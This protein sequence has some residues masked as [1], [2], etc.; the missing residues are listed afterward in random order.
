MKRQAGQKTSSFFQQGR[1][2]AAFFFRKGLPMKKTSS[3]WIVALGLCVSSLGLLGNT[4]CGGGETATGGASPAPKSS[5]PSKTGAGAGGIGGT[6]APAPAKPLSGGSFVYIHTL[7]SG[8][9]TLRV[10]DIEEEGSRL[11]S[12]LDSSVGKGVK[13][14]KFTLSPDRSKVAFSARFRPEQGDIHSDKSVIASVWSIGVDGIGLRRISQPLPERTP[15]GDLWSSGLRLQ[16]WGGSEG[17][18]YGLYT[19]TWQTAS[20]LAGGATP[21][22]LKESDG[23]IDLLTSFDTSNSCDSIFGIV[24]H[25]RLPLLLY[26][27]QSTSNFKILNTKTSQIETIPYPGNARSAPSQALW[28]SDG[29]SVFLLIK[30]DWS[31]KDGTTQNLPG[32]FRYERSTQT[33][34]TFLS[35]FDRT[36]TIEEF[37]VS[38]DETMVVVTLRHTNQTKTDLLLADKEDGQIYQMTED[39]QSSKPVW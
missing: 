13:G 36:G 12:D 4:S 1:G 34:T 19:E 24:A 5:E 2:E 3:S 39:G 6:P 22:V 18:L 31:F 30:A 28:S 27:C 37:A 8:D 33:F 15:V 26:Q 10:I 9:E 14:V 35:P 7:G 20:G 32:I 23:S 38:P 21:F 16:G 11:L 25:P 17:L 29:T